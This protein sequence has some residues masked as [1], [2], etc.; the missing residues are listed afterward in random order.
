MQNEKPEGEGII[1]HMRSAIV[2][3]SQENE[4]LMEKK[5]KALRMLRREELARLLI[6]RM[7]ISP[8]NARE[9]LCSAFEAVDQF[10]QLGKDRAEDAEEQRLIEAE[11]LIDEAS[12]CAT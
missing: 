3:V 7:R 11:R 9:S 1:E 12:K 5:R 10:L 8:S 4:E 2:R 6:S